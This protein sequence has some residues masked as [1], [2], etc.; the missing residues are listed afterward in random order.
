[1]GKRLASERLFFLFDQGLVFS[2]IRTLYLKE[3]KKVH[4]QQ[5]CFHPDNQEFLGF[6]PEALLDQSETYKAGLKYVRKEKNQLLPR[7]V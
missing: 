1:M 3:K 4:F 6:C 7:C 2:I 5:V